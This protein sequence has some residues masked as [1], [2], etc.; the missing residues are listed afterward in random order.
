MIKNE[1]QYRITRTHAERFARTLEGLSNR[2][3]GPMVC[4]P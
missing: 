2:P 1:R 3:E 4:T